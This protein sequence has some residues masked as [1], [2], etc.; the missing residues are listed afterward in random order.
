M[1][2]DELPWFGT[3]SRVNKVQRT[4]FAGRV[5]MSIAAVITETPERS[6]KAQKPV[7][8]PPSCEYVLHVDVYQTSAL[9]GVGGFFS[10]ED[11]KVEML[12]GPHKRRSLSA[13]KK[14][15]ADGKLLILR[16]C[17]GRAGL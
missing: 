11:V 9:V 14:L 5:L 16:I 12:F 10:W 6:E 4:E 15:G 3:A 1:P 7:Q 17:S 13:R 2:Q 8:P